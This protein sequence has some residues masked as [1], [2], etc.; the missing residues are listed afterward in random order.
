ME[1]HRIQLK[2]INRSIDVELLSKAERKFHH[3]YS[4]SYE[5]SNVSVRSKHSQNEF[6]KQIFPFIDKKEN[7][8]KQI[9]N[10]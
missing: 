10:Y 4:D 7:L 6:P 9:K 5:K 1:H 3:P 2:S 8:L